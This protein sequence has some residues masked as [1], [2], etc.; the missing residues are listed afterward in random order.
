MPAGPRVLVVTTFH[1]YFM[2]HLLVVSA[3]FV[4]AI[5]APLILVVVG[6]Q[7][8]PS[9][10]YSAMAWP[11]LYG[12]VPT[13]IYF[14]L[15]LAVA[16]AIT[17]CYAALVADSAHV[18]LYSA[19][20]SLISILSP[21]I[22]IASG[23]TAVGLLISCVIAPHG[24]GRIHDVVH[25]ISHG[26]VPSLLEPNHFYE[27]DGGRQAFEFE[28]WVGENKIEDVFVWRAR[29][30]DGEIEQRAIVAKYGEF[31][32]TEQE[33]VLALSNGHIQTYGSDSA[34]PS[35]V[36]FDTI[37]Q[38]VGSGVKALPPRNWIGMFELSTPRLLTV[39]FNP[40]SVGGTTTR[41]ASE[42]LKRFGTPFLAL[43]HTL[44]GL[45]LVMMWSRQPRR[46][47]LPEWFYLIL[48]AA[49]GLYLANAEGT[50]HVDARIGW[51]AAF[52]II[53]EAAIGMLLLRSHVSLNSGSWHRM[54]KDLPL[55]DAAHD[56][57]HQLM[58]RVV[59][60]QREWSRN[61]TIENPAAYSGEA[62]AGWPPRTCDTQ[63]SFPDPKG[64]GHALR[65]LVPRLGTD[66]E[67]QSELLEPRDSMSGAT[68]E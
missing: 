37:L 24:V 50:I 17:W 63:R 12:V 39:F 16:I 15:P 40:E 30:R 58:A 62:H 48:L 53:L 21:A 25:L 60:D 14:I 52:S 46:A 18:A 2:K 9:L 27:A 35:I 38:N 64:A 59:A 36:E 8:P 49:H 13:T 32:E 20:L 47:R 11:I 28:R 54:H 34:K 56:G 42:A 41:W 7:V 43:S 31:L 26:L 66:L 33:T 22:V 61:E 29:S 67:T 45:G 19:R 10:L 44:L 65:D 5:S 1:R 6:V 68:C 57:P 3:I 4:A 23:A 55:G 51:I